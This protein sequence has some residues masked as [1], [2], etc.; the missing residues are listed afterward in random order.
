VDILRREVGGRVVLREVAVAREAAARPP[1][2]D[3]IVRGGEVLAVEKLEQ[4]GEG[5]LD[6]RTD[7][8]DSGFRETFAVGR[9]Q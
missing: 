5:R 2:A 6:A 9:G 4:L 3:S 8:I 7:A 1:P